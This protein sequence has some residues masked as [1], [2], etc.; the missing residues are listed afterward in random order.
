M[1][2]LDTQPC[3]KYS[4]LK[5]CPSEG[6]HKGRHTDEHLRAQGHLLGVDLR[7]IGDCCKDVV[8]QE[9]TILSAQF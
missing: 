3:N 5:G 2:Q 8:L 7:L 4:E 1:F 9:R 6:T